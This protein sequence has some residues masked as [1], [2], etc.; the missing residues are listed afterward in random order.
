MAT[1][2]Y[3]ASFLERKCIRFTPP[4]THWHP[5]SL[6]A[7]TVSVP[8]TS[9]DSLRLTFWQAGTRL[10]QSAVEPRLQGRSGSCLATHQATIQITTRS[11]REHTLAAARNVP[12]D[13]EATHCAVHMRGQH[14]RPDTC[15]DVGGVDLNNTQ[16]GLAK[17]IDQWRVFAC[18]LS[19]I[20]DLRM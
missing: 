11:T 10:F 7:D 17:S 1:T 9:Q 15:I 4:D 12:I 3:T 5:R 13:T 18:Q 8:P 20:D 2:L 14:G 16:A 19:R 6:F